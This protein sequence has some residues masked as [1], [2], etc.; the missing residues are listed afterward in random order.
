MPL[1]PEGLWP[2]IN[3]GALR[4]IITRLNQVI[5]S[6]SSG[7]NIS[8]APASPPVTAFAEIKILSGTDAIKAGQDVAQITAEVTIRGYGNPQYVAT[9]QPNQRIMIP[10][11]NTFVIKAIRNIEERNILLVLVCIGIGL[12]E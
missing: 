3:P 6:D 1:K 9:W 8:Y 5:G 2:S 11:G 12:N 7:A 4:H 10:N